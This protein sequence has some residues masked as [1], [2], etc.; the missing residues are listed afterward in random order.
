MCTAETR[1]LTTWPARQWKQFL[2]DYIL[3]G[4]GAFERYGLYISMNQQ[5]DTHNSALPYSPSWLMFAFPWHAP[6]NLLNMQSKCTIIFKKHNKQFVFLL[7]FLNLKPKLC[8][9]DSQKA[10]SV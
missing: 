4:D 9:Q 3:T 2:H 6:E 8:I 7:P 10:A 5:S 1:S